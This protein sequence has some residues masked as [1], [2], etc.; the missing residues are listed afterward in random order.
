[1]EYDLDE[2]EGSYQG[3]DSDRAR[4]KERSGDEASALF[5]RSCKRYAKTREGREALKIGKSHLAALVMFVLLGI[6]T[7]T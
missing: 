3:W 4:L 2:I 6:P 1:M 5:D 7:D